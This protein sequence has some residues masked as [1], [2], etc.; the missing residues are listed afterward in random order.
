MALFYVSGLLLIAKHC[1][2][3]FGRWYIHIQ[4]LL[5]Y[6][7]IKF[8]QK[9]STENREIW[10]IDVNH[11]KGENFCSGVVKISKRYG[12]RYFSN[13]LDW[14]S[15]ETLQWVLYGMQHV[16]TQVHFLESFQE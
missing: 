4:E 10:M 8:F 6:D 2:N 3:P 13:W 14:F 15:S 1:D 9:T 16:L 12:K 7:C 11:I 5:F